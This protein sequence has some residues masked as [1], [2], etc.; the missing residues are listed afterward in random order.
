MYLQTPGLKRTINQ[1]SAEPEI[2]KRS[3]TKRLKKAEH[4]CE[5]A[6]RELSDMD[7]SSEDIQHQMLCLQESVDALTIQME[8]AAETR[9]SASTEQVAALD[10]QLYKTQVNSKL[11][12]GL[13]YLYLTA[14]DVN[15][16]NLMGMT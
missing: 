4:R 6:E 14:C 12:I 2:G 10:S 16:R 5:E 9:A 8:V 13:M 1:L 11:G 7:R 3:T 15:I